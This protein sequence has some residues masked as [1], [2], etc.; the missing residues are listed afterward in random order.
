M[1]KKI[2][3]A[4][5]AVL[6]WTSIAL[7]A[8]VYTGATA[9]DPSNPVGAAIESTK[10]QMK[11][12]Y[13]ATATVNAYQLPTGTTFGKVK[14]FYATELHGWQQA[15]ATEIPGQ[16]GSATWMDNTNHKTVA[17]SIMPN[18]M[19]PGSSFLIVTESNPMH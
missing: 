1:L 9:I 14:D 10:N 8:P 18:A 13:G 4:C 16:G 19:A 7:A 5:A 12:T 17:I 6:C 11:Q 15:S 3:L 2:T